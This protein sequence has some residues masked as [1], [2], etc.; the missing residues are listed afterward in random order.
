MSRSIATL[1][2]FTLLS[3]R[4]A[5]GVTAFDYCL[6]NPEQCSLSIVHVT[7]GWERH[8]NAD[9]LHVT[10]STFKVFA[11]V[12]YGHAV[13]DGKIDPDREVPVEEWARFWIGRDG[14]ALEAAWTRLGQPDSVTVEQ[15]MGAMIRES[16]N[17]AP[18]WLLNEL[19]VRYF[20]RTLDCCV[21]GYHDVPGSISAT[22]LSW[23]GHPDEPGIGP[24]VLASYSGQD[25]LGYV[26][27]VG[28]IF[29]R[30]GEPDFVAAARTNACAAPPWDP[31][32]TSCTP[33]LGEFTE[34]GIRQLLGEYFLQSTARTYARLLLGILD[35]SLL[36]GPVQEVV[37]RVLEW[38]LEEPGATSVVTR[39]GQKGGSLEP[40]NVCNW[41]AFAELVNGGDQAVVSLFMSDVPLNMPCG[42]LRMEELLE[43]TLEDADFRA[44]VQARLP[45][46][47]PR[48][49]LI[50]RFEKL[51]RK[52]KEGGDKL[53]VRLR[54][55]NI[56]PVDA[57][58]PFEVS[59]VRSGDRRIQRRDE[60]LETFV[61]PSLSSGRSTKLRFKRGSL[62]ELEGDYLFV[63]V[64]RLDEV[65]EGDEDNDRPWQL[66]P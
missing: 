41:V 24:R 31:P 50:A 3:A 9:R 34:E 2:L 23:A 38:G 12:V 58:G 56:G 39:L 46:E 35:G 29:K 53:T 52:Q 33:E 49:E 18:D 54:V 27:E 65:A 64:D 45:E 59:L 20:R 1:C 4:A 10:A 32:L 15:M 25:S 40:Q 36:P 63:R 57:E 14:G 19:G 6:D 42:P 47:A 60:V 62:M 21:E 37:T 26:K 51:K 28:E 8:Q 5:M 17:A 55:S 13:V 11:L 44:E 48:P 61:I 30:L 7:E 16:D 43:A 66:I 22:F